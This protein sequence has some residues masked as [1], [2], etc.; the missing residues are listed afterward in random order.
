MQCLLSERGA[1]EFAEAFVPI[2]LVDGET[3]EIGDLRVTPFEVVHT[4][5]TFALR[6]EVDGTCLC[7][8]SDTA[9]GDAR[10]CA[11][12]SGS[13]CSSPRRPC[14]RSTPAPRRT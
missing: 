10:R 9:P 1:R 2:E 13:T 4:V 3:I 7:Y 6:A 8:T 11:R 12:R 14:P 5:P